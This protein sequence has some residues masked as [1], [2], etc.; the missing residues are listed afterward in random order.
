LDCEPA[1]RAGIAS[2]AVLTGGFSREELL[3]AGASAVYG[4]I[5]ELRTGLDDSP[6][7]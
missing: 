1:K 7:A 6:F 3:E 5:D 4:S 2:I